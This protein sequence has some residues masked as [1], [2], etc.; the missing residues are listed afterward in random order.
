MSRS[1]KIRVKMLR[2]LSRIRDEVLGG[3]YSMSQVIEL[4]PRS[5][6]CGALLLQ[7]P[8]AGNLACSKCRKVY[9][10]VEA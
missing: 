9:R 3:G 7:D 2:E 1:V 8:V 5:P 4:W 6:C 10:V